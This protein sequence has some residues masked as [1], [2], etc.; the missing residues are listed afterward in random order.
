M[1]VSTN[2]F[3]KIFRHRLR[4]A[5]GTDWRNASRN[6]VAAVWDAHGWIWHGRKIL[7][8]YQEVI[9]IPL[10]FFLLFSCFL[11]FSFFG[12]NECIILM[13]LMRY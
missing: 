2:F 4:S 5:Y 10:V 3:S 11:G 7:E 9:K 6:V 8:K 12:M 13:C 1:V